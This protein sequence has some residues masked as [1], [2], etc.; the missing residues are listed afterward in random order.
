M[1]HVRS[2]DSTAIAYEKR[3]NGH[4]LILVDGALCDRSSGPNG[5]LAALLQQYYTVYTYDRRGR[6]DSGD[7]M[8]YAIEREIEDLSALIDEAGG[9]AYVYGISSGAALALEAA[10]RLNTIEKLAL[11]EAPYVVDSS[12]APVPDDYASQIQ[13]HLS[14]DRRGG[15]VKVF[16]RKGVGLPGIVVAMMTLMPAWSK[17][18][19][20]AHTLPY[21][22]LLTVE[23]QRGKMFPSHQ[24]A[25]VT[26]SV[27]VAVGGKSPAWMR[28]A[29]Q[30]LAGTLPNANL[31]TV[32][33]QTHI[34]KPEALV[35]VL[36]EYFGS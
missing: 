18:K 1:S 26:Q 3:G 23:H 21:D 22:T 2:Q 5:A 17:L 28:N 32:E 31:R 9:S 25:A 10:N 14:A 6:G 15:A 16:M 13:A 36:R 20:M 8:P 11:Y 34:V 27:L 24:W 7:T 33:G 30:A 19:A 4:P 12:R 29:M 35:P